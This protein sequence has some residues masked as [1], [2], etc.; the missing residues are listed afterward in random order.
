MCVRLVQEQP[1]FNFLFKVL[2]YERGEHAA[3]GVFHLH[4][5]STAIVSIII[6]VTSLYFFQNHPEVTLF[7]WWDIFKNLRTNLELDDYCYFFLPM[8]EF[9]LRGI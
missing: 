7:G 3:C 1:L 8:Q 2:D 6:I 4:C 9:R 5:I